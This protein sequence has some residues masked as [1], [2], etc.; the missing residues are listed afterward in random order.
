LR[1]GCVRTRLDGFLG[2]CKGLYG[3]LGVRARYAQQQG[4]ADGVGGARRDRTGDA[5]HQADR[6]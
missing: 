5:V 6:R 1:A 3:L 4:A 2:A